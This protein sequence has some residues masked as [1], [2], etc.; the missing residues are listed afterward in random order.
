[1]FAFVKVAVFVPARVK[2]IFPEITPPKVAEATAV[3][4]V[5][6]ATEERLLL[7]IVPPA[8]GS[9]LLEAKI[10]MA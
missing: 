9:G 4:V 2:L 10:P 3:E 7:V 8:P 5:S 6:S 1:M